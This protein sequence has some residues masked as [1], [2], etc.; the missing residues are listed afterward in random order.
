[1]PARMASK[2]QARTATGGEL[3]WPPV[4]VRACFL[5]AI[6]AGAVE[7]VPAG[8]K[9]VVQERS[10][11]INFLVTVAVIGAL[12]LG[13]WSAAA[14]VV[15]LFSLGEAIES[16]TFARTRRSIQALMAIAPETARVK[17]PDGGEAEVPVEDVDVGAVV[18]VRPGDRI[19][20][21]GVVVDGESS[22]DQ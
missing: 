6:L 13:G 10:L 2:K 4:A 8:I 16:F 17:Q 20:L 19:P 3:G 12:L 21:D 5:L 1:A 7:V 11:A 15:A 22:V 9:G 18:A 14:T